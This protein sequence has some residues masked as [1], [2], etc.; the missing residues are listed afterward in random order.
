VV[1]DLE[2]AVTGLEQAVPGF[3]DVDLN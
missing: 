3:E 2:R 1:P